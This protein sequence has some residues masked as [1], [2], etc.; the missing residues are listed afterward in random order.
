MSDRSAEVER[1]TGETSVS[2]A[3]DVDGTGET[4]VD[5]GVTFFDHM[6]EALAV[7]GR[8]DLDVDADGD[9]D[10]TGPHH[11]V[12]DVGITLG[13][14]LEKAL[15][16]KGGIARFGDARAPLDEALASVTVDVS[17][18]AYYVPDVALDG[19]A[20]HDM[21]AEMVP[22]FFRSVAH[23]AG[24]T[25]HVES[26]GDN[27]HHVAEALFKAFA[28]ALDRATRPDDR[29]EGAPSTKGSLE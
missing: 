20:I 11:T 17:G 26:H 5:T 15:G 25:L 29:G 19:D 1:E 27:D 8:F 28:L 10:A 21:E 22:H 9:V 23:N 3:L 14:A 16:D 2:V 4:D 18:R 7:H 13:R 24:L 12:E 6:L